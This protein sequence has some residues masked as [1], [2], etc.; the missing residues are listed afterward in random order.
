MCKVFEECQQ[1]QQQQQRHI[2]VNCEAKVQKKE[3]KKES[4]KNCVTSKAIIIKICV[5]DQLDMMMSIFF[6]YF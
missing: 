2:T 6:L 4:T 3:E 1:Q 5:L